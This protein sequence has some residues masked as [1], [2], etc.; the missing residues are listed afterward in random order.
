MTCDDSVDLFVFGRKYSFGAGQAA[1]GVV[2]E[3]LVEQER[4]ALRL[5]LG[6]ERRAGWTT[7]PAAM[8]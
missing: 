4:Q 3:V 1:R 7:L 2:E 6:K 5:H 8:S